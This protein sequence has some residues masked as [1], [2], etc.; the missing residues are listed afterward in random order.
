MSD[1]Q[2]QTLKVPGAT[3][4]YEVR[5]QGPLVFLIPGGVTDTDTLSRLADL[6]SSRYTVV[7]Y[8]PR[9][10]SRSVFD[11]IPVMQ[12][13]DTHGSDLAA[14]VQSFAAGPSL[15]FGNSGG[16]Q[17]GLNFTA[18]YPSLVKRLIAHEPPC[19]SL[20]PDA[21]EVFEQMR[22]VDKIFHREGTMEAMAEFIKIGGMASPVRAEDAQGEKK[23]PPPRVVANMNYF[24]EFGVKPIGEYKPDLAK[25]RQRDVVVAAGRESAGQLA[26]RTS[27]A[28]ADQLGKELVIFPSD[29]SSWAKKP[30]EFAQSLMTAFEHAE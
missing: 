23:T 17:I 11:D 12:N 18:R 25:L 26:Y 10:T 21:N 15:I 30:D 4:Y 27:Q 5:G 8:D 22:S 20:L 24:L 14:L 3:I 16:A 7:A 29:H 19:I 13:L 6:L 1:V 2:K 28:L 9:G